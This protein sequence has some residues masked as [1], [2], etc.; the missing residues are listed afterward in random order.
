MARTGR[1]DILVNNAGATWGAP[2]EDHTPEQWRRVLDLNVD[3]LF[4]LCQS[5]GRAWMIPNR[6]GRIINIASIAGLK[7][8]IGSV[9][10]IAYNTSKGAV[11]QLTRALGAEWGKYNITVNAL[12]PGWFPSRM[13]E[14]TLAR[15]G[16]AFAA[17][18]PLHKLGND[19]DLKGAA[20]LFASDAGGHITGQILAIDGG[21]SVI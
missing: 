14:A 12:A 11:V 21:A 15:S 2:A 18:T 8:H 19:G 7:G 9:G 3:G 6:R 20:L 5:V 1:I 17:G 4:H 10:T 16:E 13:T